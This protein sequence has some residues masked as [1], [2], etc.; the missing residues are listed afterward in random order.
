MLCSHSEILV[1]YFGAGNRALI[2][3]SALERLV[4]GGMTCSILL[5]LHIFVGLGELARTSHFQQQTLLR[6]AERLQVVFVRLRHSI[7][8]GDRV[9]EPALRPRDL[10]FVNTNPHAPPHPTSQTKSS[11]SLRCCFFSPEKADPSNLTSRCPLATA[12]KFDRDVVTQR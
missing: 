3:Q 11:T 5:C 1:N 4:N 2:R 8:A 12:T 6:S 7:L 10:E 9:N